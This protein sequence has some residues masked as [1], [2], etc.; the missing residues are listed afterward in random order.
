MKIC[1][2]SHVYR[3]STKLRHNDTIRPTNHKLRFYVSR[4]IFRHGRK[5]YP[6]PLHW[7]SYERAKRDKNTASD[8]EPA[9]QPHH[10]I[11]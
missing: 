2:S 6:L 7:R 4:A 3:S 5:R 11:S 10:G 1:Q 8:A 9:K